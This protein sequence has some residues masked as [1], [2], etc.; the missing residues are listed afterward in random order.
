MSVE[1]MAVLSNWSQPIADGPG[2][3]RRDLG[4]GAGDDLP[5]SV[6]TRPGL[7]PRAIILVGH[8]DRSIVAPTWS[9]TAGALL[10]R[11]PAY[12]VAIG[13]PVH[14]DRLKGDADKT[15]QAFVGHRNTGHGG[16]AD[17]I[18]DWTKAIERVRL[19]D[20]AAN[21]PIGYCGVSM[22]TGYG[23][24][25][26][27]FRPAIAAAAIGMWDAGAAKSERL[28]KQHRISDAL[29]SLSTVGKTTFTV[30]EARRLFAAIGSE[31]KYFVLLPGRHGET[32]DQ[33][34]VAADFLAR[35]LPH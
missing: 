34:A 23:I 13:G 22:G 30:N 29:F 25:L 3:V 20:G 12:V 9:W 16:V 2:L 6:W 5:L 32:A 33:I 24:P 14:G 4:R 8:G 21:L 35:S 7:V 28:S 15:V 27:A 1:G 26:L 11:M 19:I 18:A 31:R 17:M 10:E